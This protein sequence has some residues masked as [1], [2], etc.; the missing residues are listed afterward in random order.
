MTAR[1]GNPAALKEPSKERWPTKD[2][3]ER[4][5]E[6]CDIF[7]QHFKVKHARSIHLYGEGT[8]LFSKIGVHVG[9]VYHSPVC[10]S[11]RALLRQSD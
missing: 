6:P 5:E 1:I 7:H 10:V 11:C 8:T 9:S 2:I 4:C 3:G